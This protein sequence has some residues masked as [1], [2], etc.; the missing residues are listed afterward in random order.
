[1]KR[2]NRI[3]LQK[4]GKKRGVLLTKFRGLQQNPLLLIFDT[5][6]TVDSVVY[7]EKWKER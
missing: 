7:C 4:N 2:G 3:F 1:M 5:S 6:T